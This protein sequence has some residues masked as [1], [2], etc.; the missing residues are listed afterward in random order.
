MR[1]PL[2]CLAC[3][4][5]LLTPT[6]GF[7][8]QATVSGLITDDRGEP[9]IGA[10]VVIEE[11]T[12]GATTNT[13]G[14]Y[15]ITVP[16]GRANG[17]AATLLARFIGYA[18]AR[19]PITLEPGE[20]TQDFELAEDLLNL[21][22]VVV[23]GTGTATSTKRLGIN[24]ESVDAEKLQTA[25]ALTVESALAGKIAGANIQQS[26]GQPGT[27]ASITLR[28]I[29]SLG[30]TTPM[31]LIDGI[32][33]S[34]ESNYAG[35]SEDGSTAGGG[36]I[37]FNSSSRLADIDFSDVERIEVVK[38]AAAATIY[39][40]QRA[41]GVIQIFTKS[42]QAGRPRLSLTTSF[43]ADESIDLVDK[44]QFHFY[45]TESDGTIVG[46]ARNPETGQWTLPSF[47]IT[48][49]SVSNKPFAETT[50]N[51]LNDVLR[52]GITQRYGASLSGGSEAIT[53]LV[54][55]NLTNQEG[56][57]ANTFQDRSSYRANI[58]LKP[59]D[60]LDIDVRTN[61]IS[62]QNR[63]TETGDNVDAPFPNALFSPQFIDLGARDAQGRIVSTPIENDTGTNPLFEWEVVNK[64]IETVRFIT[65]LGAN[66]R[67]FGW[68]ELDYTLGVDHY[69]YTY[70]ELMRNFEDNEIAVLDP[71]V[72]RV[73]RL[74]DE[75]SNLTSTLSSFI[76]ANLRPR[77]QSTTQFAF[78]VRRELFTQTFTRGQG[79]P[80]FETTTTLRAA[81]DP[82]IDEF[83]SEFKTFGLLVNEKLEWREAIGTSFGGRFDYSSAFGEGSEPNFFP[84]GD[85]FVRLSQFGLWD[86]GRCTSSTTKATFCSASWTMAM[87]RSRATPLRRSR[88]T[89]LGRISG[90]DMPTPASARCTKRA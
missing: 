71:K 63:G 14:R 46:V 17:Q 11:L 73:T 10:N 23:T 79:L 22:E 69:N 12:I 37:F 7:A 81:S 61:F 3:S 28:G 70:D 24:V 44:A 56:V 30:S 40:A 86:G 32:E 78:D 50:F 51:A 76:R 57:L 45:D 59:L 5:V 72:G 48:P 25:P 20:Q 36:D 42:G 80:P 53:Y 38:G 18:S 16:E 4:L 54:S 1:T 41:N 27:A 31:I 52:T 82:A 89:A 87:S 6:L 15:T 90:K 13:D 75:S 39:G 55:A 77:L 49:E 66:Y 34:T 65:G 2:R 60:N 67:P 33:I 84:R 58:G 35:T 62:V 47:D 29:N 19:R 8:Q 88:A 9:L 68:L 83:R 85:L 64:N 43:S 21:E 74:A 26:S